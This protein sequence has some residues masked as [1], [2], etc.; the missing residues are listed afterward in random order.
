[1]N[2]PLRPPEQVMRLDRMGSFFATRLSFMPSLLRHMA[3]Q[4]WRIERI[5][6]D[7]DDDGFG[8]AVICAKSP[9]WTYSLVAF[10]NYLDPK[11]R[12][13]RVIAEAWDATFVLFDGEP[14]DDDLDR[15]AQNAPL[16]EAGRYLPSELVLSRANKSVRFFSHVVDRL[17]SGKQPDL[18]LLGS[19]GYLMRTTAVYGNGKFGVAD[20]AK[21]AG[22]PGMSGPFRAELLTVYLIRA[23]THELVEHIARCRAPET[24]VPLHPDYKRHLGIGNA[25]GLGMA[26]FLISHPILIHN[27][28]HARETALA[29]VRGRTKAD[30]ERLE[31][32]RN[33]LERARQHVAEWNVP[34]VRQTKRITKLKTDLDTLRSWLE[35]DPHWGTQSSPWNWLYKKAEAELSLEAQEMVISFLVE[36]H[37]DLVDELTETM[38][39]EDYERHDPTMTVC[40]LKE[41]V[42]QHYAWALEV[43]LTQPESQQRFWYVSEEK[44]E[45][46]FGDR[47]LED[48]ADK[49]MP[50]AIAREIQHLWQVLD[51][52]DSEEN[53]A[54]LLLRYPELRRTVRRMQTVSKHPYA[55]IK[56]NLVAANCLPI[57]LLRCKLSFFGAAK[58]DPKSD[59]WTRITLYQGAPL[60][61][62]LCRKQNLDWSFPVLPQE[63]A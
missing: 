30:P 50:H 49:E 10:S 59:L 7:I 16:Q 29:R 48:G 15:L 55:E 37:G 38:S 6:W 3:G 1:M 42:Q 35:D 5:R 14:S 34:D 40:G 54:A 21:I 12:S 45:P 60:P 47:Y 36:V 18:D 39:T 56:D 17:A 4:D 53:T 44:L 22:R 23:F 61:E 52:S 31:H 57:D 62:E 32:F 11:R 58:F 28:M 63:V 43:D 27:W 8:R 46:R 24:F 41:L 20:R 19:V 13:D 25:T 33:L 51:G 9:E 2:F 26:P